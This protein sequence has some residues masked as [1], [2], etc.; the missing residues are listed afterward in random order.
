MYFRSPIQDFSLAFVYKTYSFS[1]VC[2]LRLL[3]AIYMLY[4]DDLL[5]AL[6]NIHID[7]TR[8]SCFL[9][10]RID[11]HDREFKIFYTQRIYN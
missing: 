7:I 11:I 5:V 6:Y 1:Y 8:A 10:R 3:Y 9:I 2:A 4:T